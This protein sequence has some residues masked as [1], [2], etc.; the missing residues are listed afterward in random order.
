MNYSVQAHKPCDTQH[1]GFKLQILTA[2][3]FRS[4][5]PTNLGPSS[6]TEQKLSHQLPSAWHYSFTSGIAIL[7]LWRW[8]LSPHM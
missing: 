6:H 7:Y 1:S 2:A 5:C 3:P 4:M 8:P